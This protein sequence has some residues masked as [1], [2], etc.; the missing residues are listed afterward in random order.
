MAPPRVQ[1]AL[2]TLETEGFVLR[3][4]FTAGAQGTEWCERRLLARIHH[5]TVKR[6][7]REIEPVAGA[8]F[9]RFLFHWQQALPGQRGDGPQ[10]LAKI[11]EQLE[12]FEAPAAAWEQDILPLR[13][14]EYSPQWLDGL[15][16][17]GRVLWLRRAP[18]KGA[19]RERGV[20]PVKSTPIS[21][22]RRTSA[23]VWRRGD[24]ADDLPLSPRARLLAGH[25]QDHGALFFDELVAVSGWLPTQVEDSLGELVAWGLASADAFSGLRALL[26]P[27]QRRRRTRPG[28]PAMEETG[29]WA[30]VN[31]PLRAEGAD[32]REPIH[33]IAMALLRRYGVVF[34]KLLSREGAG[35]PPWRDLLT[36]YRRWEAR[37]EIRGGRF[38]AGFTGEQYA[39]PEAVGLLRNARRGAAAETL[40]SIA[41]ADPLNLTGIITPGT[42][43]PA[44]AGNR[45]LYQNGLPVAA[46]VG[47]EVRFLQPV[48]PDKQWHLH[49]AVLRGAPPEVSPLG[50]AAPGQ[51]AG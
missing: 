34:R 50:D 33:H 51:A 17:S 7:R 30:L 14:E 12:G 37:G 32:E 42:R 36:V 9:M 2:C 3:G 38:V 29:R 1:A 13:M 43:V 5:Y 48:P 22:L 24:G 20:G 40:T 47:G 10:A 25:L 19:G 44:T 23:H 26:R 39:L 4:H 27:A 41:A 6:L 15:C 11:I 8:D 21:L 28:G 18:P 49:N 31:A 35:L 46:L 45:V 16:L